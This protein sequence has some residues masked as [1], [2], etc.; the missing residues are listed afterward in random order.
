MNLWHNFDCFH[1]P[2]VGLLVQAVF[3]LK[4][5]SNDIRL[6]TV[7]VCTIFGKNSWSKIT[8]RLSRIY[9]NHCYICFHKFCFKM[10]TRFRDIVI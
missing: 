4:Y 7:C 10:I 9:Q 3:W 8:F 1:D 6:N 5:V 2:I